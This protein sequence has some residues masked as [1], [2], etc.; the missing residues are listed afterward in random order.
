MW[1]DQ[2]AAG[3]CTHVSLL[4]FSKLEHEKEHEQ[5]YM[6]RRQRSQPALQALQEEAHFLR[7]P[8]LW[9]LLFATFLEH[10]FTLLLSTHAELT[11]PHNEVP[12]LR[13]FWTAPMLP[14]C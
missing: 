12:H 4:P 11:V 3:I 9:H 7:T 2:G 10:F 13:E 8:R 14:S 1:S 5:T 6:E